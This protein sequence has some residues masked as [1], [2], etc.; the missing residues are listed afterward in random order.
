MVSHDFEDIVTVVDGR[1]ELRAEIAASE[2]S[3]RQFIGHT[4]A[5]WAE[6]SDLHIALAGQLPLDPDSQ[7]RYGL[8]ERRSNGTASTQ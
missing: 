3:L 1:E 2:T 5:T 8:L 7:Q 4:F 6:D